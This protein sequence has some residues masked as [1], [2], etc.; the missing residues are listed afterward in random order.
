MNDKAVANKNEDFALAKSSGADIQSVIKDNIGGGEVDR[1]DL[2]N[3]KVPGAGGTTWEIPSVSGKPT[4]TQDIEGVIIAM[5]TNRA[6]WEEGY[7]ESGGG[8]PPDCTSVDGFN[9]SG[10]IVKDGKPGVNECATCP[11][12]AFG[13]AA[14]GEGK[15][16]KEM[17]VMFILQPTGLLPIVVSAPPGSLK[18]M[19]TYGLGLAS[20]ALKI[21]HVMTSLSLEKKTNKGNKPYACITP[22]MVRKLTD[23]EIK[24]VGEYSSAFKP[25]E[26]VSVNPDDYKEV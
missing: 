8:S 12:N 15:A 16:C 22:R 4:A 2:V 24:A 14:K 26:E 13:T 17:R 19:K 5:Q 10:I 11:H 9:G 25:K 1:F 21:S 18:N 7:D 6:Y 23:D 3:V 20:E